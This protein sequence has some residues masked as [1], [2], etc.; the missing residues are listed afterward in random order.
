[1]AGT[2]RSV[3]RSDH[4]HFEA[5]ERTALLASIVNSSDDAIISKTTEGVIT[6]WNAAAEKIYGYTAAEIL[7]KPISILVPKDRPDETAELLARIRDGARVEHYE[8]IRIRKDGRTIAVSLTVSPI[9]DGEGRVI[10]ASTIARD[11]TERNRH[12]HETDERTALLAS[13]VNSSD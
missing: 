9:H 11:V 3:R 2:L 1:M 7:G 4:R 6:S 10:G 8:T 5:D 13:I 12:L